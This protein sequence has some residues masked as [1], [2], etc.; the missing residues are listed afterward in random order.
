MYDDKGQVVRMRLIL[1]AK[2]GLHTII[3]TR[4]CGL[5][6]GYFILCIVHNTSLRQALRNPSRQSIPD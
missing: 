4:E 2:R 6:I 1:L 3:P 5:H